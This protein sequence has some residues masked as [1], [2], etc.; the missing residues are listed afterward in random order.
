M[1][2]VRRRHQ[3]RTSSPAVASASVGNLPVPV[4]LA[5]FVLLAMALVACSPRPV[6][7]FG[8]AAPSVL[9]DQ[10]L[11]KM[12]ERRAQGRHE[13]VS[14]FNQTDQEREMHDR[15]WRFLIAAHGR[16]WTFDHSVE[17]QRTRLGPARDY[18]FTTDRYYRW[19]RETQYNSSPTR[20]ATVGRHIAADLD[21][22]PT[23]FRSICAVQEVDRQRQIALAEIRNIEPAVAANAEAR[24]VEN[25]W[26]ID[27]FVRALTYRFES[28]SYA[29]DHLLVETPHEQSM[30]VDD[31]LRR[32]APWVDR[33]RRGD[34]CSGAAAGGSA[35]TVTIPSRFQTMRI[36]TE[37]VPQ[38]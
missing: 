30:S 20:Y 36:D 25:T 24:R 7:D 29:L 3:R 35:H 22:L 16:D 31:S 37:V 32:M 2:A 10:L 34:F 14:N 21:T 19:L 12:G 13:P 33:A 9:H 28:Y 27:W 1:N 5:G 8:R 18:T 23:T 26:H 11:P 17:L 15:T 6:G 4:R 38:K